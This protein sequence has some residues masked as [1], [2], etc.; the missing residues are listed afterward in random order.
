MNRLRMNRLRMKMDLGVRDAS[1]APLACRPDRYFWE[2]LVQLQ[3]L[4][5]VVVDV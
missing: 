1:C 3:T 5:L 4:M 2:S